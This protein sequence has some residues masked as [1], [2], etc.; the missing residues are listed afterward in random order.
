MCPKACTWPQRLLNTW[1]VGIH[2]FSLKRW[3]VG[4]CNFS[5]LTPS[6]FSLFCSR[7]TDGVDKPR[8]EICHWLHESAVPMDQWRPGLLKKIIGFVSF[9]WRT[10]HLNRTTRYLIL[11]GCECPEALCVLAVQR[12]AWPRNRLSAAPGLVVIAC[13]WIIFHLTFVISNMQSLGFLWM[14]QI[15]GLSQWSTMS[16]A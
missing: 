11:P 10:I 8:A 6:S 13:H 5:F 12:R 2:I 15:L 7:S 1:Q 16:V 9:D 14:I 4:S 3:A